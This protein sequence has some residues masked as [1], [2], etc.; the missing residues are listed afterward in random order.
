MKAEYTE[1]A[2]SKLRSISR[3]LDIVIAHL[4]DKDAIEALCYT[5]NSLDSI[6]EDMEPYTEAKSG[7]DQSED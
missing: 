3:Q 1:Q 5:R 7:A 6:I 4:N 2:A